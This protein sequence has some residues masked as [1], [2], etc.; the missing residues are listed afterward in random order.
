MIYKQKIIPCLW[1]DDKAEEAANFYVSIFNELSEFGEKKSNEKNNSAVLN[2]AR[3]GEAGAKASGMPK[4]SVM[5]VDFMLHGQKFLALNAGPVFKFNP[6]ISFLV[7]CDSKE[8]TEKLWE[9]LSEGGEALMEFSEYPFS[10]KY[11]WTRDKYGLSWQVMYVGKRAIK[12][13]ITPVLMFVHENCGKAEEAINFYVSVFKDS[14]IRS[15]DIARYGKNEE[16]DKEGAIKHASFVLHGQEFSAMDS[17]YDHKFNFNEAV[18]FM[19]NCETQEEIDYYWEN[20]SAHKEAEQCGWLKDK[21]G[22]S[23]QIVP[24]SIG[25]LMFDKEK[26]EKLMKAIIAMKKIIIAEIPSL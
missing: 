9:R 4:G 17:A 6:A 2:S 21:Y 22:L 18:S 15:E 11:G 13:K 12:Q 7:K 16:P 23:L 14:E 26:S 10:E 3:Y 24:A 19:V 25:E 20:L 5:I 8:E 1:F